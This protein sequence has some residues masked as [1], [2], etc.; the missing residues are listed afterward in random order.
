MKTL[1][2]NKAF[3]VALL[4]S[5][6]AAPAVQG[7]DASE[8]STWYTRAFNGAKAPFIRT[9]DRAKNGY[10]KAKKVVSNNYA[11]GS[12]KLF[13]AV[14]ARSEWASGKLETV[15]D[16]PY[17]HPTITKAGLATAAIAVL[18]KAGHS[19]Y[20]RM[21]QD[22]NTENKSVLANLAEKANNAAEA[23]EQGQPATFA[24]DAQVVEAENVD[25]A[26]VTSAA[27]M[28]QAVTKYNNAPVKAKA[29]RSAARLKKSAVAEVKAANA[30]LQEAVSAAVE[31]QAQDTLAARAK[32]QAVRAKDAAV[33]YGQAAYDYAKENAKTVAVGAV[34]AALVGNEILNGYKDYTITPW[35]KSGAVAAWNKTSNYFKKED[36]SMRLKPRAAS[37][38]NAKEINPE[39]RKRSASFGDKIEVTFNKN[40]TEAKSTSS[41]VTPAMDEAISSPVASSSTGTTLNASTPQAGFGIK[42]SKTAKKRKKK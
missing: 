9:A 21:N 3:A 12:N 26:V 32:V 25:A 15:L 41:N 36:K 30:V 38:S 11:A 35:I 23:A 2:F 27:A 6:A 24:F 19:I 33:A 1:S 20:T 42:S 18:A 10:G 39:S 16:F 28:E 7:P 34:V 40:N 37:V 17:N 29:P 13:N 5:V 8:Q 22:A 4:F 31:A 14:D